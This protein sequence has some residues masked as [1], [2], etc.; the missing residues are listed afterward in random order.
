MKI[1][2]N[3]FTIL[4]KISGDPN[5]N[6]RMLAKQL[7]FSLGKVNYCLM[8]LKKRGLIKINNFKKSDNKMKY[9]YILTPKGITQKSKIALRFLKQKAKEYEELKREID[10]N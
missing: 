6:Q 1:D 9:S 8:G 5:I 3:L 2:E 10:H 4:R 7:K